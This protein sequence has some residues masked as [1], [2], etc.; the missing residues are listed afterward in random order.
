[1]P[2]TSTVGVPATVADQVDA[3]VVHVRARHACQAAQVVFELCRLASG[4]L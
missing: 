2:L 1:M 3:G 4:A